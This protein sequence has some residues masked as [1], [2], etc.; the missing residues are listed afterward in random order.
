MNTQ[1]VQKEKR[2]EAVTSPSIAPAI[3]PKK[4]R[5]LRHVV[6]ML[7]FILLV[8]APIGLTAWYLWTRATDRYVSYVGFSVRTEE[9]GSAAELLGGVVELSG[10]SSSDTNILYKF[11]QSHDLIRTVD[12]KLD[13][14]KMWSKADPDTD[15]V[16]AY[17]P[18]GTI[19]DLE[20][21]WG[22]MVKVYNDSGTG[23]I[24]LEVQAFSPEDARRLAQLIYDESSSMIN[25]LS[26]LG[27]ED[28]TRY[29]RE[30]L[31]LAIERLKNARENVTLFR[32]RTQIVDTEAMLQSQ[33]GLLSSLQLQLA[34]TLIEFDMLGEISN[35]DD[36][37][38]VQAQ[39]RIDI[40]E[41]RIQEERNKLGLGA[42][43]PGDEGNVFANLVG[44]YER[45]VVDQEFAQQSYTAALAAFDAASAEA[46][47]QSRYLAAHVRPTLAEAPTQPQRLSLLGLVAIFSFLSWAILVLVAYSLRDRR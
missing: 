19:E 25:R 32:N 26:A 5:K 36:P 43:A 15:P 44:E 28:A 47:R 21:Y 46:R 30:E 10:S 9:V 14:R 17:H 29:A 11:I 31:D 33:M 1:N 7:S 42:A 8:V 2:A 35:N 6:V 16:F 23:L 4:R 39:R 38:K 13:L 18:P 34:E 22:R 12:Q 37:R 45:L 27:Q 20:S 40:I 41:A 3:A 24:D